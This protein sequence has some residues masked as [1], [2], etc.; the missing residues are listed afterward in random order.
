MKLII[1]KD[2][3]KKGLSV[4]ERVVSENASLPILK[5]ILI[6]TQ[7]SKIK[8]SATNLELGINK[9]I[10]GKITE[11]G[12]LTI[13]FTTFYSL[14]TNTDTERIVLETSK[15]NL[16]FKTDNYQ[17]R[18]QGINEE[19]FPLLPK[20][21]EPQLELEVSS[22]A[23][24]EALLKIA[25]AAQISE[26]R[27]E[28]SGVLFDFQLTILKLVATDSFRLAQKTITEKYFKTAQ[29]KGL[30]AIIPLKTIQEIIRNFEEDKQLVISFDQNQL[31]I[32]SEDQEM[33]SRLIDGQYPDYEQII[34]KSTE[35]ELILNKEKVIGAVR[36]VSSLSGKINDIKLTVKDGK[37]LEIYSA[38]QYL[39]EGSYLVP[40]KIQG[41]G[42]KD[43][44]F[45]W[46]Y[47]LE[48]LKGVDSETAFLGVNGD[49]RP[50]I[51]KSPSEPSYLYILMPIKA[52]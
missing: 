47:L 48:G 45:N 4:I 2:N 42:F 29:N 13:P 28:L 34:P 6:K 22:S 23:L 14:V 39:G 11:E 24:K 25:G 7:S 36:L 12:G 17:A 38:S 30:K 18:L 52:G 3:L 44:T 41:P 32:K 9:F 21:Q 43:L 46:R 40:A 35:T 15:N 51:I 31:F 33:I 37:A 10:A 50:S 26:I 16:I 27:P 5:N 19:E 1:L 8:I 20:I 49:S